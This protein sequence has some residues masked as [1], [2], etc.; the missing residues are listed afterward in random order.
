M[1]RKQLA[2]AVLGTLMAGGFF[3]MA[4]LGDLRYSLAAFFLLYGAVFVLYGAA[5]LL[6]LRGG[7][8]PG[9]GEASPQSS[10]GEEER[11]GED[12]P[13]GSDNNEPRARLGRAFLLVMSFALVFRLALVPATPVLSNDIYRYLWE[14]R[15]GL[16]GMNPFSH[17]P[18]DPALEAL[19]DGNYE[20]IN[21]RDLAAI[22]PPLAQSVFMAGA[23]IA[24]RLTMQKILFVIFDLASV[25]IIALILAARGRDP[26]ASVVYAWNPLVV[27]EFAHSGHLDSLGI[28]LLLSGI[29][30]LERRRHFAGA[31]MVVLSFLA[32]YFT[33]ILAPFF[34]LRKRFVKWIPLYVLLAAA[35]YLPFADAGTKLFGSLK[36]YASQW[37][38]N[39]LVFTLL[40]ITGLDSVAARRLLLVLLLAFSFHQA[41]RRSDFLRY[42]YLVIGCALLLSPTVYPWYVCWI[43]PFLCFYP[44]R[45]WILF[46]FLVV[47][48][49]TVHYV[50]RTTNFWFLDERI[51]LMEYVPFY[52]L[53]IYG[54]LEG[55]RRGGP[56]KAR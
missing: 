10:N 33:G 38:F 30:F 13:N 54:M 11:A 44:N 36:L 46:T 16:A 24:P 14:G 32:K 21:H 19:R 41:H 8:D 52:F 3:G 34:L 40:R 5:S 37:E 55:L 17:P 7:K 20:N 26:A 2:I 18:D 12:S 28:F 23:A 27:V 39:S 48:S 53:L 49:Y 47:A 45:A 4:L 31:L 35:A 51:L 1:R 50:Y 42:S 29:L 6:V 22:Y 56:V 9:T 15:V 25:L 43:V